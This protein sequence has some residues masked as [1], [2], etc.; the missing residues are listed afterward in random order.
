MNAGM[1]EFILE[2]LFSRHPVIPEL[3]EMI[4]A[5]DDVGVFSALASHLIE[6]GR[7]DAAFFRLAMFSALEGPH[8][9]EMFARGGGTRPSLEE[10]LGGYI[11]ERIEDGVFKEVNAQIAA[12]MFLGAVYNYISEH[13]VFGRE[14][15]GQFSD[16]EVVETL[17]T[18]FLDGLRK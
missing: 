17:V 9:A 6:H 2:R 8:F 13:K 12:Q 10:F 4:E 16:Q 5:R 1:A 7:R 3:Q 11:E 14:T 15:P 18:I